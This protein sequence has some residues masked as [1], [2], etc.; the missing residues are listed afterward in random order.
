MFS[1]QVSIGKAGK[2][3]EKIDPNIQNQKI[4]EFSVEFFQEEFEKM[5]SDAKTQAQESPEWREREKD[6]QKLELLINAMGKTFF[7]ILTDK[8]KSER[9]V[10]S[11]AL[12]DRAE[13]SVQRVLN[14]GVEEGYLHKSTIGTKKGHGRT[15]RYI[16]SRRLAPYFSLDPTSFS[17][18]LFVTNDNLRQAMTIQNAQLRDVAALDDDIQLELPIPI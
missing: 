18:Y 3:V 4:R 8:N 11:I 5:K 1:E 16:L 12:S 2:K 17:G 10:F 13:E 15:S 6:Y 14:L 9:R 7:A